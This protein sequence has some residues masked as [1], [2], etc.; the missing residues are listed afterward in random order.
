ML[1][2]NGVGRCADDFPIGGGVYGIREKVSEYRPE[3]ERYL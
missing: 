3:R 2:V 1:L